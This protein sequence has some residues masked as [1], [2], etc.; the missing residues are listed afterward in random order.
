[1][2]CSRGSLFPNQGCYMRAFPNFP[3][4]YNSNFYLYI[5]S[6]AVTTTYHFCRKFIVKSV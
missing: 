6:C 4:K 5:E 1:M 2:V 3:G